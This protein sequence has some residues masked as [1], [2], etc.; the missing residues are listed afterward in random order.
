MESQQTIDGKR[1]LPQKISKLAPFTVDRGEGS[2]VITTDGERYLD[3]VAGIGVTNT[4]HSHPKV[5]EA[6]TAQL[7]KI[8][9]AQQNQFYHQ[10][11]IDLTAKV[12]EITPE[13][14]DRVFYCSTGAEAVE[15]ACKIAKQHTRRPAVI[16]FHNSF[17]GRTHYTMALTCSKVAQRGTYEPLAGSVYHARFCYPYR[18]PAGE[19]PTEWALADLDRVFA[20]EVYPEDVAA[21]ILETVQGEGGFV[22][23][24]KA[25]VQRLR[26]ICDEH[27]I[28]LITDEIQSGMGRTGKWFAIEHYDVTPDLI[29]IS[30]GIASGLPVA[31]VAGRGEVIDSIRPGGIGGTFNGNVVACAAGCATIDA[32]RDEGMLENA[33]RQ[34]EKMRAFLRG[35]QSQYSVIGDVRGLGLMNMIELVEPGTKKTN[36]P[37]AKALIAEC[38]KRKLLVYSCCVAD[39]G[40]RFLP[41][42]NVS[43]EDLE[44]AF[45]VLTD[46]AAAAWSAA[47]QA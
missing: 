34:G 36:A 10:P 24:D 14:I 31:L 23:P 42:I 4:G 41:P 17:H 3:F 47:A 27:G 28:C 15:N 30:K 2:W 46:A 33:T 26:E 20:S 25:F 45:E 40:V 9:H 35:L 11:M 16:A 43:D 39:N 44:F 19:D 21:I 8:I 18:T 29:T 13:G 32:I 5:V 22:V 12:V 1:H 6:A 7:A 38:V 37:A